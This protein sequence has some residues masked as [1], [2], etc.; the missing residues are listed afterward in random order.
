[1][2]KQRVEFLT[3]GVV[4][5]LVGLTP[6]SVRLAAKTGKLKAAIVTVDGRHLFVMSD[7]QAWRRRTTKAMAKP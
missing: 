3:P 1:M 7:V 6:S 5:R 2:G 4:A